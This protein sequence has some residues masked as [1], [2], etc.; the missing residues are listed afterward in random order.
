MAHFITKETI[1]VLLVPTVD[2]AP[3][4]ARDVFPHNVFDLVLHAPADLWVDIVA[5]LV[6]VIH[7]SVQE[8]LGLLPVET[9]L[10]LCIVVHPQLVLGSLEKRSEQI[11]SRP[12]HIILESGAGK[13]RA[14]TV[15]GGFVLCL[16]LLEQHH[17]KRTNCL[18][19]FAEDSVLQE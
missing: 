13:E 16:V 8:R 9:L 5:K 6:N 3:P 1:Q 15:I 4:F 17:S 2:T 7:V 10:P 14:S 11:P 12:F 18:T 19:C